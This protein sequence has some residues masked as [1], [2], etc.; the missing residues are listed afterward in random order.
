MRSKFKNKT[1][2]YQCLKKMKPYLDLCQIFF[3]DHFLLT[4][5]T[6]LIDRK[7][8]KHLF[9]FNPISRNRISSHYV[10]YSEFLS[11]YK[12]N[13]NQTYNYVI[14]SIKKI[15]K[16][17]TRCESSHCCSTSIVVI[18]SKLKKNFKEKI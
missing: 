7:G 14:R 3:M 17:L 5:Y 12:S 2:T 15:H 10:C 1:A 9:E 6:L 16:C 4:F 11:Y 13:A 18:S 8:K